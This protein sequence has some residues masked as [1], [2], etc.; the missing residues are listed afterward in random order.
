MVSEGVALED[1]PPIERS[2]DDVLLGLIRFT[3]GGRPFAMAA[4]PMGPHDR[5]QEGLDQRL[6]ASFDAVP[7]SGLA[8]VR[9]ITAAF[10][11]NREQLL[12]ALIAYD[13]DG[14]LPSRDEIRELATQ[15]DI[16]AAIR[17]VRAVGGDPLAVSALTALSARP[18][19]PTMNSGSTPASGHSNGSLPSTAGRHRKS[20]RR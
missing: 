9:S 13:R 1:L 12:D 11:A 17:E 4:L 18:R 8:I 16:I 15:Q 10:R 20:K 19:I 3:L 7:D 14:V 6:Q 2:M 5:W